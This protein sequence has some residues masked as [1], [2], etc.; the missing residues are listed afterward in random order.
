MPPPTLKTLLALMALPPLRWISVR[1][2]L[3]GQ[4][5]LGESTPFEGRRFAEP[6]CPLPN[7][8]V[9][10]CMAITYSEVNLAI[11]SV[12]AFHRAPFLSC[13]TQFKN[14]MGTVACFALDSVLVLRLFSFRSEQRFSHSAACA[15]LRC[16]NKFV[17]LPLETT[18]FKHFTTR[19]T[20]LVC[21]P[22]RRTE[23][24]SAHGFRYS[25]HKRTGGRA[26]A[27]L[28]YRSPKGNVDGGS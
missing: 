14:T 26:K 7:V 8:P 12:I 9:N 6:K 16:W 19:S 17:L 5:V 2:F 25:L 23:P 4:E 13:G 18:V 15:C 21:V 24:I 28:N 27:T 20:C 11:A 10:S 3:W 22:L 1:I